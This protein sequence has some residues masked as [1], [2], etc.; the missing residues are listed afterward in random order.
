MAH[1]N[2]VGTWELVRWHNEDVSGQR[3]H[4][5]GE[6]VSGYISYSPDGFVFVHMSAA[7]RPNYADNDPFTGTPQEH[8]AAMISHITYAGKYTQDGDVVTHHVTQ[9]SCPN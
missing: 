2:L 1:P 3:F 4:P 8:Q 9:S 6:D 5:F 7:D